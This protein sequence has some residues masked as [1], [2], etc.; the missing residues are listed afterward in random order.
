MTYILGNGGR[1]IYLIMTHHGAYENRYVTH[2]YTNKLKQIKT[3]KLQKQSL[4][5]LCKK[6]A[7]TCNFI[8]KKASDTDFS[9]LRKNFLFFTIYQYLF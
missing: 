8:T 5:A 6:G 2:H 7:Y 3:M 1:A 4:D 9:L